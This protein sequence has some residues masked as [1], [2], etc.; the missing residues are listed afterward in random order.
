MY[1]LSDSI[2]AKSDIEVVN[3]VLISGNLLCSSVLVSGDIIFLFEDFLC[4]PCLSDKLNSWWLGVYNVLSK[5]YNFV[6][7]DKSFTAYCLF[8]SVKKEV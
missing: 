7:R 6:S 8:D 5:Y 4:T 3:G 1:P 2:R